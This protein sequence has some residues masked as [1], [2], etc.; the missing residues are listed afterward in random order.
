VAYSPK[1]QCAWKSGG[2]K[3]EQSKKNVSCSMHGISADLSLP[4]EAVDCCWPQFHKVAL[5]NPTKKE[6]GKRNE[7][8]RKEEITLKTC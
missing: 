1:A 5:R 4:P 7:H 3:S 8:S 2:K 6:F